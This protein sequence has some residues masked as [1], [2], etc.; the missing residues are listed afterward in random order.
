MQ[1]GFTRKLRKKVDA[2]SALTAILGGLA[3]SIM[4]TTSE[5]SFAHLEHPA[6]FRR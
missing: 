5:L 4:L 2:V 3:P 1:H 6:T